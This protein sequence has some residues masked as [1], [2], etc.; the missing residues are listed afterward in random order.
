MKIRRKLP[1]KRNVINFIVDR[2]RLLE[3]I[4]GILIV[5]SLFC[6][7]FVEINYDLKEYL[8]ADTPSE[9]G[10]NLMEKEFGYPGIAR[11]M[12][13]DVSLYEAKAYKEKIEA[14][15]GVDRVLWADSETD[16][17]QAGEF[18][19][20]KDIED[21]YKNRH[22]VMDIIFKESDTSK[23][24]SQSIDE[25]RKI[26]GAKG[27]LVGPAVQDK[28]VS[29]GL[30]SEMGSVLALAF[31]VIAL[32]LFL[33]TTSWFEPV[34][35]LFIMA[36]VII[37][38]SGT[39]VFLGTISFLTSNVS[40]VLLLACSMDFSIF[41][42]HAFI[43]RKEAG[44]EPEQAIRDALEEAMSSI[45]PSGVSTIAGFLMLATMKFTIGFDLGIVLAKGIVISLATV[46]CLMPAL[47]LH[48]YKLVEK[49]AHRPFLPKFE[50]LGR[51][52]FKARYGVLIF[53]ALAAVPAFVAQGMNDF[54]YGGETMGA[55]PG[56]QMY[57]DEQAIDA[58]FGR[59]NLLMALYPNTSLVK[60]K[61]LS[62]ELEKLG[63]VKSVTSLSNTLPEGVP[64]SMVPKREL[65]DLHTDRYARMM[66][67][68]RTKGESE[69]AF[70]ASDEIQAVVK[71]YYPEDS[72]VIG[73]TPSTQDIKTTINGDYNVVDLLSLAGVGV[74]YAITFQ[75]ALVPFL[76][77]IPVEMTVFFD[78]IFPYLAGDSTTFLGYLIVSNLILGATDDYG[79][80][81]TTTYLDFRG[82][83][84]RKQAYIETIAT[85][86][87]SILASG[88]ILSGAG[89]LFYFI[90]SIA[91]IG[92]L[93]HLVGRGAL[94][95]IL[96]MVF[97]LPAILYLFDGP[98][99]RSRQRHADRLKRLH[100]GKSRK[101]LP[102]REA[103]KNLRKQ[104]KTIA[105]SWKFPCRQSSGPKKPG[106]FETSEPNP[107]KSE[108]EDL[109]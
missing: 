85:C 45:I 81:I 84:D 4:F 39:N 23:R 102:K 48:S 34:L 6:S 67:Y 19:E 94:L 24:T 20:S 41:L 82:R 76:L 33:S 74:I 7:L 60:E 17:Y 32:V 27:H 12:V 54:V 99:L 78:M 77:M 83:M 98:I 108:Q 22:S 101:P 66:I 92:D 58:Q 38:N 16:V 79:I 37:I 40:S 86:T 42:L 72:H 15:D 97:L 69:L 109:Q 96:L 14:I 56:T 55:S 95:S 35:F 26:T 71:K 29:E 61:Q 80:L 3:I 103:L 46:L 106:A 31:A 53:I 73:E 13:D 50:K 68:I 30:R 2:R 104:L 28:T 25:I 11:V 52:S 1:T 91:A 44:K 88:M 65:N 105:G 51:I 90:S 62:D 63:Y 18:V 47:I 70:H 87:P 36:I 49:T 10:I 89:Y 93:G 43:R 21:Y 8:P 59:S 107:P 5:L 57:A 75:S 100:E 9:S 64:A